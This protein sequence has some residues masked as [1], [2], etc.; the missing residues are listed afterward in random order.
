MA[1]L[2][3]LQKKLLLQLHRRTREKKDQLAAEGK[4]PDQPVVDVQY[5]A[6]QLEFEVEEFHQSM[7]LL[8]DRGLV[9]YNMGAGRKTRT[10]QEYN[11]GE[12]SYWAKLTKKGEDMGNQ[13]DKLADADV[14]RLVL[15]AWQWMFGIV[16]ASI[17]MVVGS[18]VASN[19]DKTPQSYIRELNKISTELREIRTA[20]QGEKN[21]VRSPEQ[22]PTTQESPADSR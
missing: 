10:G 4:P 8:R 2:T 17:A 22:K 13:L 21:A 5:A 16:T 18:L 9:S 15:P 14:R 19:I 11:V 6:R 12:E 3:D 7:K 20:I 1:K